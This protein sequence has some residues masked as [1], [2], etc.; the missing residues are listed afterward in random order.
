MNRRDLVKGAAA[1][2]SLAALP[3]FGIAQPARSRVLK[4]V[5]QANLAV[6]D[7]I[8]TTAYITRNH[9]YMIYDT[10]YGI[11]G[12]FRAQPQMA[13]GMSDE[14][15]GRVVTITIRQGPK[16][17]DGTPVL[18]RDAVASLKRWMRRSPM[19]QKLNDFTDELVA[20]DDR[21]LQFRLKQP[22]PLLAQA[23]G[24][25]GAPI[26]FIMPE[27]VALTD[28]FTQIRETI[29]SGPYRFKADEFNSGS[30]VVYERNPEYSPTPVN[31]EGMTAGPKLVHFD[32]V[33]WHI[34]TDAATSAGA[35]QTGEIDWYEQPPPEIQEL[36]RRQRNVKVEPI[37]P[38]PLTGIMRLNH[39]HPPF[40]KKE[41]RQAILPAV[42]QK[43]FMIAIVGPEES[44]Y[45]TGTGLFT[46]GSPL[47]ND[48][49]MDVLTGPRSIDRAKQM[50]K[51]AGYTDQLIRLIGSTD[52]LAPTAMTQVA[53]DMFRRL[54]VNFDPV[55][56]DWGTVVQRRASRE[57]L[58]N[59]GWSV[60][61]TAF[62]S[63]DFLDPAGHYPLRGNGRN[64]WFG[65]PTIPRLEELR[66]QWFVAPD[67][68]V[69]KRIAR[70]MQ[71]VAL[72]EVAY[73][74]LGSYM[75]NTALNR[76]L[77]DRVEGFAIFWDIKRA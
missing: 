14:N 28:P 66:D 77:T 57:P 60:F 68:D 32:R 55:L 49:G 76:N 13:E 59:G 27:R 9:G 38:L 41:M 48:A 42:D 31:A 33:E 3:R 64:A 47:A 62:A 69:Q 19:G 6:L 51:D 26:P 8:W 71:Q 15:G 56:T 18:A 75:Q 35:L 2:A 36:L 53:V 70:E 22:F 50:L 12:Q 10:L 54:G 21:R 72:D 17:H 29:G 67:L 1:G 73:I 44:Q 37:D 7:P 23:L 63:F 52:I 61:C 43:D 4:F 45:R 34:I 46:P 65:W 16:F 11:D 24:N 74:P 25:L 30:M 58:E 20:V 5:P 39:L 40:D